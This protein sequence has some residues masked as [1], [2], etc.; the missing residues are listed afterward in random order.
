MTENGM[1]KVWTTFSRDQV[2]LNFKSPGLLLE[3]VEVF[4]FYLKHNAT[5][6]RLDAIAFIWKEIGTTCLHLNEA[7]LIVK[8]FRAIA[9]ETSPN[10][11]ITS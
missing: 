7:H 11:A 8:L 2:D 10:T 6:I 1:K 9:E 3:M 4:L 5:M